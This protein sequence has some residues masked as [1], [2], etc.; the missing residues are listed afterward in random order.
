M[1][2]RVRYKQIMGKLTYHQGDDA[3][4]INICYCDNALAAFIHPYKNEK[5][6]RFN[7]LVSFLQDD[8]HIDNLLKEFNPSKQFFG[9]SVGY[10]QLNTYF[11]YE[12]MLLFKFF[13]RQGYMVATYFE[14][15]E[16]KLPRKVIIPIESAEHKQFPISHVSRADLEQKGFDTTDVTDD[17]MEQ[18]ASIMDDYYL[19][20][21]FWTDLVM[22]CEECGIPQRK[23]EQ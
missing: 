4:S 5:G 19:D 6:E 23:E 12:S 8:E 7:Q 20:D 22:A 17:D 10:V 18:I 21:G 9:P 16:E 14:E 13:T 3:I 11:T 15:P 2:L 1:S